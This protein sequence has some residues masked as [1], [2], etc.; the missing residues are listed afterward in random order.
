ML[1]KTVTVIALCFLIFSCTSNNPTIRPSEESI[2]KQENLLKK[3]Y[4]GQD[5]KEVGAILPLNNY[6]FFEVVED[7]IRYR[8]QNYHNIETNISLGVF[9]LEGKLASIISEDESQELFSC[10]TPFKT[11][12]DHWLKHGVRPY[13]EWIIEKNKL[14]D[15]FNYRAFKLRTDTKKSEAHQNI[16][17]VATLIAYSPFL[18]IGSPFILYAWATGEF[19]KD[20]KK[21]IEF[22]SKIEFAQN[23]SIG[24]PIEELSIK[25]GAPTRSD[26]VNGDLALSYYDVYHTFGV[27]DNKVIWIESPSMLELYNRQLQYGESFY[28]NATCENLNNFEV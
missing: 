1:A 9:F 21:R 3:I 11:N 16:E 24:T 14:N 8:Y 10:R 6:H 17:G 18:V 20:E 5:E 19:E 4:I 12:G 7:G 25:L 15:G 27:S 13:S 22:Q 28:G 23:V 26:T 2:N